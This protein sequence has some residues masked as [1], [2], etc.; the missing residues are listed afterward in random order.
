M[1]FY[2]SGTGNSLWTAKELGKIL[3]MPVENLIKY[4]KTKLVCRDHVLGFVF[5]TYMQDIPWI[6]KDILMKAE[7]GREIYVFVIMT[8]NNGRSGRAFRSVDKIMCA[9]GSHLSAGFDLR[10]PGNCLISSEKE[11]LMRL[12][13]APDSLK[14]IG[15]EIRGQIRNYHS[16]GKKAERG[17]VEKSYFYGTHSL[18]KMTFMKK[19]EVTE[20]C[21]GC[22]ICAR[23]CPTD[24]IIIKDGKAMHGEQCAACYA[25]LHWCPQNATKLKVPG[26]RNR[27]QYHHP[28][29]T[30][31]EIRKKQ[32]KSDVE[33]QNMNWREKND[34]YGHRK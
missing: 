16:S 26:L 33:D 7:F 29:V 2:F 3:N 12:S 27:P 5:P 8:S 6:V 13:E 1:I 17:F 34:L 9:K 28:Q 14:E 24:N 10:M 18:K 11:N 32:Q 20:E 31:S 4:R 21:N 23:V 19:F 25:C 15:Q 30:L 22:G